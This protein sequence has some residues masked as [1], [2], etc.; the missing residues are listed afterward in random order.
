MKKITFLLFTLLTFSIFGQDK[1]TSKINQ[2]YDGV[3]WVNNSRSTYKYNSN[4]NLTEDAYY[5][6][7]S[8]NASWD[9]SGIDTYTYNSQ[10]KLVTDTY[11][12]IDSSTGNPV[13]GYKTIYTYNSNN[14]IIES[15]DQ[16]RKNNNW[17]NEFRSTFTYTNNKI[18]GLLSEEWNGSSWVLVTEAAQQ[19]ASSRIV[20][21]YGSN[22]LVS[23]FIYEEWNGSSW[24]LDSRDTYTY[25]AINKQTQN[26]SQDWNGTSYVNNYKS[27]YTY[28]G[29]GNLILEKDFDFDNGTFTSNYEESYTFDTSQL[30]STIINP[31]KDRTGFAALTGEDTRFVNKILTS[32]TGAND[33]TTYYYNGETA[34]VEDFVT[35][36]FKAYPNPTSGVFTIDTAN[37]EVEKIDIFNVSGK[38]VFSTNQKQVDITSLSKGVYLL[39][40]ETTA[41]KFVSKRIIKN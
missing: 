27:E 2:S 31:F 40:L 36:N 39:K 19:D 15:I 5:N 8:I 7:N 13:D 17:V 24:D 9:L 6:W 14:Q 21:N 34:S 41:G 33:R 1:L 4:N 37:F 25:N 12:N 11:E 10:N 18:T 28:D 3:N 20:I 29:N 35:L 32:S 16:E 23:E 38:K 26:I 22:N 30:M